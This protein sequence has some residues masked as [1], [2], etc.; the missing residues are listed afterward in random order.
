MDEATSPVANSVD[1]ATS[2]VR[3]SV[4]KATS[5]MQPPSHPGLEAPSATVTAENSIRPGTWNWWRLCLSIVALFVVVTVAMHLG[6]TEQILKLL[7]NVHPVW[8]VAAIGLQTSTYLSA[9]LILRCALQQ[10]DRLLPLKQLFL[11]SVAKQFITQAVPS[12]GLSGNV[13]LVRGLERY[14]VPRASTIRA[15][16]VNVVS[17]YASYVIALAVAI[18]ILW[19]QRQLT[20]TIL[21]VLTTL[22]VV[23]S[24]FSASVFWLSDR[25]AQILPKRVLASLR[26]H[27]YGELLDQHGLPHAGPRLIVETTLLQLAVFAFDSAT[28]LVCMQSLG[29]GITPQLAFGTLVT[30][31]AVASVT[32][33]PGGLGT[34]EGTSIALLHAH[35]V[36]LEAAIAGTMLLRGFTFWLPML[37]GLWLANRVTK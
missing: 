14:G 8:I 36:D 4:D 28:L 29:I 23:L 16:L 22:L 25:T 31:T 12:V 17:Y 9:G 18:A 3:N 5:P 32:I 10:T 7:R 13:M 33:V 21:A 6:E 35:G 34:F 19:Q 37:P 15:I 20:T 24:V 26:S 1:E 27:G 2:P 11:L 30:S